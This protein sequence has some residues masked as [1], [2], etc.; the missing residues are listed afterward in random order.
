VTREKPKG[1]LTHSDAQPCD[2]TDRESKIMNCIANT[3]AILMSTLMGAFTET[4]VTVTGNMAAGLSDAFGGEPGE[5]VNKEIQDKLPEAKEKM[6]QTIADM[7]KEL[8]VQFEQKREEIKPLLSDTKFDAGPE[9]VGK[10]DFGL[11]KLTEEISD[12]S[13]AEYMMLLEK[14][15]QSFIEMFK[16]LTNWMNQLPKSPAENSKQQ[17]KQHSGHAR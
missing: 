13:F 3:S 16:E 7:R 11:Q 10:Y 9:I 15:D 1:K 8:S 2:T 6:R 5:K 14:E 17:Q 12:E 4:I